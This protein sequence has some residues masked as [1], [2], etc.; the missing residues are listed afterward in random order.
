MEPNLYKRI[1]NA[2]LDGEPT[3][4]ESLTEPEDE[5]AEGLRRLERVDHEPGSIFDPYD[6]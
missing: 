4:E 2:W 3:D 5:T 6:R 1:A